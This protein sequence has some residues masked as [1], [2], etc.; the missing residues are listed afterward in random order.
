MPK[1]PMLRP[2]LAA[3]AALMLGATLVLSQPALAGPKKAGKHEGGAKMRP[4]LSRLDLTDAQ[5][6]Q[7]KPILGA[8]REKIKAVR[9]DAS[10]TADAKKARMQAIR[11]D[12][13]SQVAALLTP[14]QREKLRA[15][16]GPGKGNVK[17]VKAGRHGVKA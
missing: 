3:L 1:K 13:K 8:A 7:I 5:K 2:I 16:R 4:A 6:A 17:A 14:K 10:L 11:K 12:A 15:G 9:A